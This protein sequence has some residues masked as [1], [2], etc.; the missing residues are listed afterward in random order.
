[1][2]TNRSFQN[3]SVYRC[4]SPK[5]YQP[6]QIISLFEKCSGLQ[7]YIKTIIKQKIDTHQY[8][9]QFIPNLIYLFLK[10]EQKK[11]L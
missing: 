1:M 9:N 11:W 2:S 5:N 6:Y 10:C 3:S 7:I 4:Q 8:I